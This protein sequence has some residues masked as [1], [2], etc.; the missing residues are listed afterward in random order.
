MSFIE[1]NEVKMTFQTRN[2][3]VP[4][5]EGLS[6]SAAKGEFVS[7]IGPSGS[8]KTTLLRIIGNL[9]EPTSGSVTIAGISS[10]QA[11]AAGTFSYVFQNPVLLPWRT[12]LRNVQLPTEI[13]ERQSRNP[14]ELLGTVGLGGT[15][16]RYPSELSGGMQQRVALARALTFDPEVLLMDEP[17]GALDELTRNVLNHELVRIWQNTGVTI[18]FV[19]HS[20]TEALFLGDRVVVLSGK[21]ASV[22]HIQTVP[23]SRPRE[24]ALK[25]TPAFQEVVKCLRKQ[26]G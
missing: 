6:L 20:I 18:F 7:I 13:L 26:L 14:M 11:R 9:L 19:T 25:E 21:P 15:E 2:H 4:V 24:D 8:G 10:K 3:E 12:V 5:L 1:L 23:F 16:A 22:K 17:F